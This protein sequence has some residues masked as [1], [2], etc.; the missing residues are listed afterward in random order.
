[1]IKALLVGCGRIGALLD[2]DNDQVQTHAKALSKIDNL[3]WDIFDTNQ[4]NIISVQRSYNVTAIEKID[5]ATLSNYQLVCIAAPT[6]HHSDLL[7]QCISA[8]VSVVL[9]EKPL[10]TTIQELDS[11]NEAYD[12][13]QTRVW[14]NYIRRYQEAYVQLKQDISEILKHEPCN[15]IVVK[16]QRGLINNGS[17]AADL[18]SFLFNRDFVLEQVIS[19][20]IVYDE[21]DTDPTVNFMA[22]WQ[23]TSLAFIGLQHAKFSFFEIELYFE[24]HVVNM[25]QSGDR[26]EIYKTGTGGLYY[27][28]PQLISCYEKSLANYMA[29][30]VRLVVQ[31]TATPQANDNFKSSVLI[32]KSLSKILGYNE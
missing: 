1:M 32:T 17:H 31:A 27:P 6:S 7:L 22:S 26:I 11:L 21:F 18:L 3:T 13:G 24:K 20:P 8:K 25:I 10:T 15:N 12:Q 28:T 9:C 4:E 2:I 14:V 29:A 16:Y 23:G 5:I 19:G 30:P